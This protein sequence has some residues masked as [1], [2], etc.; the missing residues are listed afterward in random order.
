MRGIY[1]YIYISIRTIML[2]SSFLTS[3]K[4]KLSSKLVQIS[5]CVWND[6]EVHSV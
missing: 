6:A 1:I 3:D 4:L 5:K 2:Q